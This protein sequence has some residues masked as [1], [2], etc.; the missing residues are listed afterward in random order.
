MTRYMNRVTTADIPGLFA[1]H[2]HVQILS[3]IPLI[4]NVHSKVTLID[5]S[6]GR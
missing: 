3:L 2:Q 6:I 4:L 1:C 5:F